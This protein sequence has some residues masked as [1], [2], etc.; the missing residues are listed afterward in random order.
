M[1]MRMK[2]PVSVLLL[3]ANIAA[4][5]VSPSVNI[6]LCS[7]EQTPDSTSRCWALDSLEDLDDARNSYESIIMGTV[8]DLVP[9]SMKKLTTSAC[10]RLNVEIA[11]LLSM[12]DS[13]DAVDEIMNLWITERGAESAI[14]LRD[15]ELQCSAGLR[16]EEAVLREMIAQYQEGWIEPMNR[17]AA[18]LY[19]QGDSEESHIWCSTVLRHKPWHFEAAHLQVMN[20]LRLGFDRSEIMRMGRNSLPPIHLTRTRQKWVERMLREARSRLHEGT[21]FQEMG[22]EELE[23]QYWQ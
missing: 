10:A 20:G 16:K 12:L 18:V 19:Y 17:L 23:K 14:V 6:C 5:F 7:C 22:G 13:D 4:G 1:M 3:T 2:A 8:K 11:L 21:S 9:N 15:M